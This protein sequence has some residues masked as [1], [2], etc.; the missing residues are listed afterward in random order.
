MPNLA[1]RTG[2]HTPSSKLAGHHQDGSR[3]F[4]AQSE[5]NVAGTDLDVPL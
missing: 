2:H 5:E 1:V 4:G 3:I